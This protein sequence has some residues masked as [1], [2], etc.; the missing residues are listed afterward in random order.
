MIL[1]IV[2]VLKTEPNNYKRPVYDKSWVDKLYRG[3][4]RNF[5]KPFKFFCLTNDIK[6]S[7]DYNIIPLSLDVWGWWNKL[8]IFAPNLFFGPT[9]YLDLDVVICKD[10]THA[11]DNLPNDI[12]LMCTEPYK[13]LLNSSVMYWDSNLTDLYLNFKKNQKKLITKYAFQSTHQSAIGDG[14]FIIDSLL[15][16]AESFDKYVND[17]FF[18]WKHHKTNTIIKDPTMLIFTSTEKPYNNLDIPIVKNNWI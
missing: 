7:I 4:S 9:L 16:K 10:F 5:Q 13:N 2:C 8:D 11:V 3:V 17:G 15:D 18:N 12:L 6:D 1:N 14:A